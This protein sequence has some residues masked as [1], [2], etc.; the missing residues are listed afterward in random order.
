MMPEEIFSERN[1]MA[2]D[3]TLTKVLAYDIIR[4]K[5]R[6]AGIASVDADN[7]YDRI[8]HAIASLVFQSFGVPPAVVESMLTTIQEMKFFLRTG[9]GDSTDYASSKVEI[10]TQGLCQGNGAAPAGWAVVSICIIKA[11]KKKGHGTHFLCPITKLKNHI[12][13]V[14]YMDNTN[15]I[16]FC[17]D[18]R[19]VEEDTFFGIQEAIINWGQLLLASGG[20]LKPAKCFFHLI[21]FKWNVDGKCFYE[22]NDKNKEFRAVVPLVDGSFAQIEHLGVNEP[23]KTLGSLTCPS[24]CNKGAIKYMQTKA[25]DW[26]NMVAA[27]K[28]GRWNI[29]FMMDKQFFPR[30]SYGLCAVSASYK[31]LSECLMKTYY[32]IHPQGG[33]QRT[34]RRGI[35]QLDLG[36]YGVGC[37][38]PAIECLIVQLNKMLMHYGSQN[39]LGLEMQALVEL[40]VI[41]LGLFIQPFSKYF[42]VHHHG[43]T[44]S[45]MKSVWEKSSR[46]QIDIMLA[47]LSSQ[48]PR[49]QD[50]WLMQEF[51]QLNYS[52]EDL[53]C[54]NRVRMHQQ[55]LDLS[56]VMDASGRA[57]DRKYLQ[58][59]PVEEIW[60]D[61]VFPIEFLAPRDFRI[62]KDAIPQIRALRGRLN[63]GRYIQQGHKIWEW[64]YD[65]EKSKLYHC[66][67]K[68]VD[69]YEPSQFEG[70]RTR[71]N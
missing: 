7:C 66:K 21:L 61:L 24:G 68:L 27:G 16:H 37:P 13:G 33:I 56:D 43:V 25:T 38:H 41:E 34:A 28:L 59:R 3:G 10:K 8:A 23:T 1:K 52:S 44:H 19:Q 31:E 9:L 26:N 17:M 58:P 40:L 45:W 65:L 50:S 54:L 15:L 18:E 42:S 48:P 64:R 63:L 69:I 5:K 47:D 53:Q 22:K 62:W 4:Q 67:G 30:V 39:C 70:I 57:I 49:E 11:H 46:L 14:I 6:P 12:A 60:S 51:G 32:G 2:D 20:A 35:R 29:W 55:V 36:F 71:A